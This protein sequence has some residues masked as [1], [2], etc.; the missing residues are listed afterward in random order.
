MSIVDLLQARQS[1]KAVKGVTPSDVS[2]IFGGGKVLPF[3]PERTLTARLSARYPDAYPLP[4]IRIVEGVTITDPERFVRATVAE[5]ERYVRAFN[6]GQNTPL[7]KS[8][9]VAEKIEVLKLCGVMVE[10]EGADNQEPELRPLNIPPPDPDFEP[11]KPPEFKRAKVGLNSVEIE[12]LYA[13]YGIPSFDRSVL[14]AALPGVA[15]WLDRCDEIQKQTKWMREEFARMGEPE[16][17]QFLGLSDEPIDWTTNTK[18][19][20]SWTWKPNAGDLKRIKSSEG[21][22]GAV[23]CRGCFR[24]MR[25][26]I[27]NGGYDWFC[28]GCG[29]VWRYR[30]EASKVAALDKEIADPDQQRSARERRQR[31][32]DRRDK[33]LRLRDGIGNV[34][35]RIMARKG[36]G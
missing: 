21:R 7:G 22:R 4:P 34:W 1:R 15:A 30:Y 33:V 23:F 5:L 25:V 26:G 24:S 11:K 28:D 17:R 9:L 27:V 32:M 3:P 29:V 35:R 6:L 8:H 19:A 13:E 36:R 10:I 2:R 16:R 18:P 31:R 12:Q 20:G 14:R